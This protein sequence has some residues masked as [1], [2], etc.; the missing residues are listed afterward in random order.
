MS[1]KESLKKFWDNVKY[2]ASFSTTMYGAFSIHIHERDKKIYFNN[3]KIFNFEDII[4]CE[5]LENNST[6]T[7]TKSLGKAIAGGVLAGGVGAIIGGVTGKKVANGICNKLDIKITIN[8][9][10]K[11]CIYAHLIQKPI[12]QKSSEYKRA[13][14][15]AQDILSLMQVVIKNIE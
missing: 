11:P 7:S 5:L 13:Y 10:K 2:R 14:K 3:G 9:L 15:Q 1:F 8:D 4:D 12:K 6:V